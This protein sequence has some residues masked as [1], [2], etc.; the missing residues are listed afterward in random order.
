MLCEPSSLI[1]VHGDNIT[2]N[3][4]V[5]TMLCEEVSTDIKEH[6]E[7][8]IGTKDLM[9]LCQLF[10]LPSDH[11]KVGLELL[12]DFFWLKRNA[13]TML[14]PGTP[15]SGTP[16][17][18]QEWETRSAKF[19]Q[20]VTEIQTL[21]VKLCSCQNRELVYDLYTYLW[22][23][24]NVVQTLEGFV[25]WMSK[26]SCSPKLQDYV[27]GQQTWF[28]GIREA[29]LSGDHEPWMFRGG[30]VSDLLRL[31]PLDSGNDLYTYKFPEVPA[32]LLYYVRPFQP[33]D[34]EA[35]YQLAANAYEETIDAPMGND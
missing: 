35:I 18:R 28:S 19:K 4:E 22:D 30:L 1:P 24:C 5:T 15:E 9:L 17:D 7:T 25:Q 27:V 29:F 14:P 2:N 10:F 32:P 3:P 16:E 13:T 33:K 6:D 31:L 23:M 8:D 11:G 20:Y 12:N 34:E 26:G 21:F